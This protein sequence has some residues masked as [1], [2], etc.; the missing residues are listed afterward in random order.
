MI[1]LKSLIC[2]VEDIPYI[3]NSKIHTIKVNGHSIS[4]HE[5]EYDYLYSKYYN[6]LREPIKIL[7]QEVK[8]KNL[9]AYI[10]NLKAVSKCWIITG[11]D[12][13]EEE[14]QIYN[15][16]TKLVAGAH[17]PLSNIYFSQFTLPNTIRRSKTKKADELIIPINDYLKR[18]IDGHTNVFYDWAHQH[19]SFSDILRG[20]VTTVSR[21]WDKIINKSEFINMLKDLIYTVD[22]KSEYVLFL[23]QYHDGSYRIGILETDE[24]FP[25][26][27]EEYYL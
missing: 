9:R 8:L 17:R 12:Y 15:H 5:V 19:L 10:G 22:S 11:T 6:I 14:I 21:A 2:E 16:K 20:D 13:N 3:D 1:K 25:E 27:E 4:T 26:F 7:E 18:T 24:H 23:N